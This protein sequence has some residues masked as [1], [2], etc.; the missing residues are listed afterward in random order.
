VI[1][2]LVVT[3]LVGVGWYHWQ[4]ALEQ[5]TAEAAL[6]RQQLRERQ[7]DMI[8]DDIAEAEQF[9]EEGH[10]DR[11]TNTLQ[12]MDEKL[13]MLATAANAAGDTGQAQE[14]TSLHV[15]VT[16]ALEAIEEAEGDDEKLQV[17]RVQLKD[18]RKALSRAD[19]TPPS[20][21]QTSPPPGEAANATE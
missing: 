14:I 21:A 13:V 4:I 3:A 7:L 20:D 10:P 17:A 16:N 8:A 19:T 18:L 12:H 6:Q 5:Q 15:A 2:I 9:L 1:I 11:V